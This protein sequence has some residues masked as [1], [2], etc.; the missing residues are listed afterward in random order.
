MK[1]EV[2]GAGG[3]TEAPKSLNLYASSLTKYPP[4]I[5][6]KQSNGLHG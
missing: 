4:E 3:R 1:L 2:F 5:S 6:T